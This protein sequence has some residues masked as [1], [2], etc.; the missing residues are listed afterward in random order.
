MDS[1]NSGSLTNVIT[2]DIPLDK[3]C[4]SGQF[5]RLQDKILLHCEDKSVMLFNI[6]QVVKRIVCIT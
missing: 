2:V 5:T 6:E 3:R 1:E 4:A